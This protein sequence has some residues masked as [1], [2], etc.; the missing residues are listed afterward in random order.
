MSYVGNKLA[1]IFKTASGAQGQLA[2]ML[3]IRSANRESLL[4][5][6]RKLLEAAEKVRDLNDELFRTPEQGS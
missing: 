1:D 4:M 5:I 6:E 2:L 3:E